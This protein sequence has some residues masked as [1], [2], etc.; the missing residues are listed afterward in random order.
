[1][2][3]IKST[4]TELKNVFDG[5]ISRLDRSKGRS[6]ELQEIAIESSETKKQTEQKLEKHTP[7]NRISR[8]TTKVVTHV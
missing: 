3:E 5:L 1:M 7:K 8:K 4:V 2:L 6:S